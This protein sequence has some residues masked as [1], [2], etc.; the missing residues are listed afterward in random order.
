M[1]YRLCNMVR[2]VSSLSRI[3][4]SVLVLSQSLAFYISFFTASSI[5]F[6]SS[7]S[8]Q[9]LKHGSR[10]V[11]MSNNFLTSKDLYCCKGFVLYLC[12]ICFVSSVFL[13]VGNSKSVHRCSKSGLTIDVVTCDSPDN[14]SV[15]SSRG[16]KNDSVVVNKLMSC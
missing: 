8:L 11:A 3:F 14:V 6:F 4:A 16:L 12:F 1:Y 2:S 7:V 15:R 9:C 13:S 10:N 5:S